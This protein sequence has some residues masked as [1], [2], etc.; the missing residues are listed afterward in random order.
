MAFRIFV[1]LSVTR[2]A[3]TE[4]A[5]AGMPLVKPCGPVG[6]AGCT[7]RSAGTATLSLR[8]CSGSIWRMKA[9]TNTSPCLGRRIIDAA[10]CTD[11][12]RS[13]SARRSS[14]VASAAGNKEVC[15]GVRVGRQACCSCGRAASGLYPRTR[16]AMAS[17]LKSGFCVGGSRRSG[18]PCGWGPL[19]EDDACESSSSPYRPRP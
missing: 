18:P 1:R 11:T 3:E 8:D 5:I 9:G 17:L 15:T 7:S 4:L 16:A 2:S 6:Y 14:W 19:P 12:N 10:S 13:R